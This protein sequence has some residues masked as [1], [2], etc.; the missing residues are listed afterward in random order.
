ME[1]ILEFARGPLFR[2]CFS[3]MILGLIRVLFLEFLSIYNAYKK[4]GDKKMPWRLIIRRSLEW[5]FP[6]KKVYRNRPVYSIIS[7]LFHIGLLLVPIFLLAHV[8]LWENVIGFA[9]PTLSYEWA[10]V[11]SL[12]TIIFATALLVGRII[13]KSSSFLSRKQDY[14]WPLL[15]L[16]P[17]S[18]G[19]LCAHLNLSPGFY[20][21]SM[22]VHVLAGNLIFILMPFT[23]IAHCVLMPLSQIVCSLAWKFPP[24]TDEKISI[25]LNKKGAPV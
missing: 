14:L 24:G 2:L 12:S 11:L 21:A 17:F 13:N 3:I 7:I 1:I 15:L 10:Y 20:L 25:T 22:L 4:A 8:Q 6:V 9:W 16:V 5:L 19:F 23:K 18:S